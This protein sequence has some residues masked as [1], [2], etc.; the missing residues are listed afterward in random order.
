MCV[1]DTESETGSADNKKGGETEKLKFFSFS[2]VVPISCTGRPTIMK[3]GHFQTLLQSLQ[4]DISS[5]AIHRESD[6]NIVIAYLEVEK[7]WWGERIIG[8]QTPLVQY[9]FSF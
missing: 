5:A 8:I 9:S 4:R 3:G 7:V 6:R 1:I 2:L